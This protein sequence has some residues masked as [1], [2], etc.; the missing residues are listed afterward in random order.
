MATRFITI[1]IEIM[2][3]K[4]LTANQ[5]FILAEIEQLSQLE[6]GCYAHNQHF[7][8]LIGIAKES[9]SRSINDMANKGYISVEITNGSR[10]HERLL[11]L[12]KMLRP[13]K[14]NVK[15][16]LTKHQETKG[17]KTS[18]RTINKTEYPENLNIKAFRMWCN[19]KGATYSKQGK[20]LSANKLSQ[21]SHNI[22]TQMVEQAIMNGWKGL[23]EIK[24]LQTLKG[25]EPQVGSL[26]W[27]RQEHM[28]SQKETIDAELIQI[29]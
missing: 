3:D 26:E 7:A 6:H 8:D 9:V 24:T 2:H 10:N 18:N 11:T 25:K 23:F 21:Y 5:K 4:N 22:Q 16:P 15:T 29:G 13:P 14:Q 27:E 28:N 19:H 20:T 12:N 1:S 17:N